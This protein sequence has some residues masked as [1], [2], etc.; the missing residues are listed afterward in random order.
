MRWAG[1]FEPK[2][3]RVFVTHGE[4]EVWDIFANRL[5]AELGLAATAPCHNGAATIW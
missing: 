1:S 3:A 2:P 4:D 5:Q